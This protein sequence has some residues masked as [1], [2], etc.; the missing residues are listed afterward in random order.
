MNLIEPKTGPFSGV[1][2]LSLSPI[3]CRQRVLQASSII[4]W[5]LD[6]ALYGWLA[7]LPGTSDATVPHYH[8]PPPCVSQEGELIICV[9]SSLI[10]AAYGAASVQ[11]G[12]AADKKGR[13]SRIR[14]Q[15]SD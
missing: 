11:Q 14:E 13:C 12:V 2:I 5:M 7:L 4:A 10:A 8:K 3:S 1:L 6:S 9:V 15:A